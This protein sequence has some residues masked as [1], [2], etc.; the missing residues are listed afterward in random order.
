MDKKFNKIWGNWSIYVCK[1]AHS[2]VMFIRFTNVI[3]GLSFKFKP[4]NQ[5]PY[6]EYDDEERGE[7]IGSNLSTIFIMESIREFL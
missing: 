5:T 4:T 6:M 2:K 1:D 3:S 7:S